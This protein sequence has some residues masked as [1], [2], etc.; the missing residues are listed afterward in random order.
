MGEAAGSHSI[1]NMRIGD[2]VR[3][4]SE[5]GGGKVA[6]FQ[7]KNIVL[8]EDEDGFQI[9]MPVNEV[10][11]AEVDDYSMARTVKRDKQGN[12]V[13]PEDSFTRPGTR[14]VSAMLRDGQDEE[15]DMTVEDTIDDDLEVTFRL[16]ARERVGGE[17]LSA[18]IAFVPSGDVQAAEPVFSAYFVNDCNYYLHYVYATQREEE[19]TVESDGEV[20][21]NTQVLIGK[22]HREDI[23]ALS[24]VSVQLTAYK[25][26]RPYKLKPAVDVTLRID[27]VRF[28][29]ANA[30]RTNPYFDTPALLY[31]VVENDRVEQAHAIDVE[32]LRAAMYKDSVPV[33]SHA[34]DITTR[35]RDQLVRRYGADQRK[36]GHT[37]PAV[38]RERALDD[39]VVVDLHAD[40]LLDTT[41]GMSA[42]EILEYQLGVMRRTLDAYKGHRGQKIVFIHGKGEGVLR[43]AVIRELNYKYKSYTYQDASFQEYGYGATM[44]E[45]R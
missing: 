35:Q 2:K 10:V 8:V 5:T 33:G 30:F 44:V 39:A 4:L 34:D 24:K 26:D 38:G 7:G 21:P 15:V 14:S 19:W 9:P 13:E 12:K 36:G 45:I 32:V 6:G 28:F 17:E 41:Q 11:V 18:Y 22:L 27:P 43:R 23:Q 42:G 25:R 20:E 3:F 31:P 40:Q 37:A 1:Y 16:P 29:K